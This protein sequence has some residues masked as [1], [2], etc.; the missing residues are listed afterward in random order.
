MPDKPFKTL[1]IPVSEEL[2]FSLI[3]LKGKMHAEDWPDFLS[4]VVKNVER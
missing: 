1:H 2:Y 4:K 3:E